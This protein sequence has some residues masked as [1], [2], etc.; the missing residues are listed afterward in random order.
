MSS[1]DL[2]IYILEQRILKLEEVKN[3]YEKDPE[4]TTKINLLIAGLNMNIEKKKIKLAILKQD[5][6]LKNEEI[7]LI[8]NNGNIDGKYSIYRIEDQ[9]RMGFITYSPLEYESEIG[10]VGYSILPPFREQ[11]LTIKAL[12]LLTNYLVENG[13]EKISI[14]AEE[15]NIKSVKVMN[16]LSQV[17]ETVDKSSGNLKKYDYTLKSRGE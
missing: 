5:S 4:K 8:N 12:K 16:R 6:L 14:V 17:Y 9:Q 1:R 10:S 2:D 3:R 11:G 15:E 7:A 13:V